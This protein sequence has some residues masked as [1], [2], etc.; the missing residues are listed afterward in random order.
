ML[1]GRPFWIRLDY[2]V[3]NPDGAA[4]DADAALTLRRLIEILSRRKAGEVGESV[5]AGPFRLN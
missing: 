1:G 2:R 5:T 3:Q 4:Q